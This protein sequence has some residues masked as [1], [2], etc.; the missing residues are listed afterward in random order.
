MLDDIKEKYSQSN[1]V[2]SEF[3]MSL[4]HP[5][6]ESNSVIKK[7]PQCYMISKEEHCQSNIWKMFSGCH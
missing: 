6:T 2:F 3:G 5:I 4:G 1:T 7:F